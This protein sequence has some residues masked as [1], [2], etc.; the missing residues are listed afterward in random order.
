MTRSAC[1]TA[2]QCQCIGGSSSVDLYAVWP[3]WAIFYTLGNFSKPVA[4]I[5]LPKLPTLLGNFVKVS[6]YFIFLV[7]SF[8]ATFKDFWWLFT[9]H[10]VSMTGLRVS[11]PVKWEAPSL[12][13]LSW[14]ARCQNYWPISDVSFRCKVFL[15]A[16]LGTQT[17]TGWGHWPLRLHNLDVYCSI[18]TT[19]APDVEIKRSPNFPISSL[20]VVAV[21]FIL[22]GCF[23]K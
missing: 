7:K 4:T 14:L 6:I 10:A 11:W 15:S 20:K 22:K 17:S 1:R 3:D 23:S 12:L 19:S 18:F 21:D 16:H 2:R 9:G 8:L 13:Q 5:I